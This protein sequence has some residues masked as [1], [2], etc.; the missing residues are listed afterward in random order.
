MTGPFQVSYTFKSFT[1]HSYMGRLKKTSSEDLAAAKQ[2]YQDF[3]LDQK[4]QKL[5]KCSYERYITNIIDEMIEV[6]D[7]GSVT[8]KCLRKGD[9]VDVNDDLHVS[10]SQTN[11]KQASSIPPNIEDHIP[12]NSPYM[13]IDHGIS[14]PDKQFGFLNHEHTTFQFIGPDKEPVH[15]RT[16]EEH[17]HIA[18]IIRQTEVP[19]YFQARISIVCGLNFEAWEQANY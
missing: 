5:H 7:M 12:N 8:Q 10:N 11:I 16:I 2:T 9:K 18:E 15:I 13:Q 19:N 17:L 1:T 3:S 6:N 4:C 14:T